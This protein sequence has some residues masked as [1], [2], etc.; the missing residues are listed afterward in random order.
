MLTRWR[1]IIAGYIALVQVVLVVGAIVLGLA[2]C[3]ARGQT[4][5]QYLAAMAQVETGGHARPDHAI[6]DG[7]R[8]LGRYQIHKA[9]WRDAVEFDRSIGG[10]YADVRDPA[11]A[12]RVIRA[13]ARRH[14]AQALAA[15]DWRR[16]AQIHNGGPGRANAAARRYAQRLMAALTQER[17][18]G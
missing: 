4:W 9:Y 3:E 11:Y 13:Y 8:A 7:G 10:N 14:A 6:G 18:G 5:E 16:L 15:G 12:A 2:T 1:Y 17:S